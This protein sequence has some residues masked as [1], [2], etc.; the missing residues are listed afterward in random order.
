MICKT[1]YISISI[2]DSYHKTF[3]NESIEYFF[4][5]MECLYHYK[6]AK[7]SL[8]DVDVKSL[9]KQFSKKIL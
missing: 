4:C 5:S 2:I 8:Q 3:K 1:C 9:I 6:T 7:Q